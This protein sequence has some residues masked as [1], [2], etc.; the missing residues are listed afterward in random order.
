L[1]S[2]LPKSPVAG[3]IL[4]QRRVIK[5]AGVVATTFIV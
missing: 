5:F 3:L 2:R 4:A 1:Q